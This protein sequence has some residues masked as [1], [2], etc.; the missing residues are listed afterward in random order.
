MTNRDIWQL[1]PRFDLQDGTIG[2][3]P[4]EEADDSFSAWLNERLEQLEQRHQVCRPRRMSIIM[5]I[6]SF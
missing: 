5:V 4:L 2:G 3:A 6:I 1:S